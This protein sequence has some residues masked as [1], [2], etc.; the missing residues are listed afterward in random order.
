MQRLEIANTVIKCNK[1][2]KGEEIF[3]DEDDIDANVY[4]KIDDVVESI[5]TGSNF[6]KDQFLSVIGTTDI[7]AEIDKFNMDEL[8]KYKNENLEVEDNFDITL[9]FNDNTEE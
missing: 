5:L 3:E 2:E 6:E 4:F 8:H 9:T 7:E 1:D